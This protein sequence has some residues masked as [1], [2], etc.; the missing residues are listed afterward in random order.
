[1][2]KTALQFIWYDKPKSI[3][4]L[5]GTILSVFLI[6]QQAGIFIFLTNAMAAYVRLAPEYIWV[7]DDK[8]TNANALTPLDVRVGRELESI[9]GVAKA[10]PVVLAAGAAKFANGKS[11]GMNLFGIQYPEFA[12][13][14]KSLPA[15]DPTL[16]IQDGAIFFDEFDSDALGG[17]VRGDF[18]ELNGKK[19]FLAGATRGY[20]TFGGVVGFTTLERARAIGN[21][22]NNQVSA[23]LVKRDPAVSEAQVLFFINSHLNGVKAWNSGAFRKETVL[24]V[25]SS[26]GIALSFGTL[27]IFALIVGF[28]IIGLTLYS[29]AVDRLRDYGTLKAIGA[30]NG[31]IA[32]LIIM[33]AMLF[34]VTGFVIGFFLVDGFRQGISNSG[35]I[36]VF[37][38]WLQAGFF[39]IT[40]LI[41]LSG[42]LFAVRRITGLEPSAVFRA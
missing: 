15:D 5:A 21:L 14:P 12:G 18:F 41:A 10:Y 31:Y 13:F 34:G 20:R 19:V 27:I 35:T 26:S 11:S 25:L 17:A 28:V 37:P 36:F 24:T 6:G 38:W 4:A 8:T 39:G 33:Q 2:L 3:G 16:L 32:Q 42:S 9:E 1:M 22:S 23:Y 30:T 40:L 29:A 7:V